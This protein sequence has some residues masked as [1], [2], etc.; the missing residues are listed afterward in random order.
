MMGTVILAKKTWPFV[1]Y[2][3]S[4]ERQSKFGSRMVRFVAPRVNF[5]SQ[6]IDL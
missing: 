1:L 6:N 4:F 2:G 3:Q 5:E